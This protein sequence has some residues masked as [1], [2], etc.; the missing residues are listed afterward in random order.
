CATRRVAVVA[1]D[2]CPRSCWMTGTEVPLST[3][4]SAAMPEAVTLGVRPSS[5][6]LTT[7][8]HPVA[9]AIGP[10]PTGCPLRPPRPADHTLRCDGAETLRTS[11]H[12]GGPSSSTGV[13]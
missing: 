10:G 8:H 4:P 9:L 6:A 3:W 13:G 11:V 7:G 1:N 2:E 12:E 5:P